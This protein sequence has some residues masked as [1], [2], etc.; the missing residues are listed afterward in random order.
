MGHRTP[1]NALSPHRGHLVPEV[2]KRGEQNLLGLSYI[3]DS[4]EQGENGGW[5]AWVEAGVKET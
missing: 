3:W 4:L 1:G 2:L 5:E